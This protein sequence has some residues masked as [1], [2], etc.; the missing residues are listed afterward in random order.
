MAFITPFVVHWLEWEL[1]QLVHHEESIRWPIAPWANA[2]TTELRL[3]PC[4]EDTHCRHYM[5]YVSLPVWK[6]PTAA[7]TW[8]TSRSLCGRYPLPPLHGLRLAPCVEDTHCRHYMGYVSLPVWKIA[9]AATTWATSRSL[10]GRY[11]LPPLHGLR[12]APLALQSVSIQQLLS[13]PDMSLT[14]GVWAAAD[15]PEHDIRVCLFV[16]SYCLVIPTNGG[17]NTGQMADTFRPHL[18]IILIEG[19]AL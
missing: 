3:A 2:L 14:L 18:S 1:A 13:H 6:I 19:T 9:T 5:G 7:T 11:P 4:V 12:L 16:Y 15:P 17:G 8:A 10:C